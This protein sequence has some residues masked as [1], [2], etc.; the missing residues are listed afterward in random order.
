MHRAQST[1]LLDIDVYESKQK[2]FF[3]LAEQTDTQILP[4]E[5]PTHT[6]VDLYLL[7]CRQKVWPNSLSLP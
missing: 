3:A 2:W 5:R 7:P 6:P 4:W 1:V